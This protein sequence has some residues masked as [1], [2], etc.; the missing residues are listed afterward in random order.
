MSKEP[1]DTPPGPSDRYLVM[2]DGPEVE[3]RVKGSRFVGQ[4]LAV[5]GEDQAHA[6]LK[7]IR[8]R[9]HDATHHCSAWWVGPPGHTIERSDDDGEPSGTAGA[10]ILHPLRG[11]HRHDGM[12]VVTRWFGGTKLGA[13]GLVRAYGRCAAEAIAAAGSETVWITRT[14]EV[15]VDYGD[16][17]AVEAVLA[18]HGG[19]VRD[20]VR[21]FEGRPRFVVQALDTGAD[22]VVSALVEATGARAGVVHHEGG[23]DRR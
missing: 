6:R 15:D 4:A 5:H 11:S 3:I 1:D 2:T 12:V 7:T 17:G 22:S 21:H 20:V 8:K 9:H 13:G 18:R 10:P 16:V 19:L 23:A 14:F